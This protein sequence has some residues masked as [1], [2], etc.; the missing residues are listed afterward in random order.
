MWKMW[1]ALG[2]GQGQTHPLP[3]TKEQLLR[4]RMQPVLQEHENRMSGNRSEGKM[5]KTQIFQQEIWVKNFPREQ[6][7]RNCGGN[8]ARG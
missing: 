8:P 2:E 5:K 3:L 4:G 7:R 6:W 1:D